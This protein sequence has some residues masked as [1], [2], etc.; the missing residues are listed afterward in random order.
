MTPVNEVWGVGPRTTVKLNDVGITNV[1][2]LMRLDTPTIR[3]RWSINLERTVRELRGVSCIDFQDA[4][5]PR[6]QI[7]C[8]RSFG[9]PV[10]ELV[11]LI[12]AVT[13]FASRA[14]ER[15]RKQNSFTGSVLV[16]IHT[17]PFRKDPQYSRSMVVP[18]RRPTADTAHIVAAAL[19][20]LK[21]IYRPRFKFAKAGVML[22]ELQPDSVQQCE[23]DLEGDDGRDRGK[24]MSTLDTLNHRYGKGSVLMASAGL[25]GNKRAW[26]M[27]QERRTPGYTTRF[28]DIPVARS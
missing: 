8:T 20:G 18:L 25:N 1:A 15:L 2:E 10:T 4:P 14:A 13:E 16:F 19:A 11:P 23:L 6:Q 5:A 22:M 21:S 28:E 3:K 27:K 9:H 17:S 26:S 24:L 7:A 12:E